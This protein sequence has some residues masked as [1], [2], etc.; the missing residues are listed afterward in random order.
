MRLLSG[1]Q[2]IPATEKNSVILSEALKQYVF[3]IIYLKEHCKKKFLNMFLKINTTLY[4][5]FHLSP[6]SQEILGKF[7]QIR[8]QQ[9]LNVIEN[10]KYTPPK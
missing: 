4:M 10:W 5:T 7:I 1:A 8:K 2:S 9:E 6:L 3:M